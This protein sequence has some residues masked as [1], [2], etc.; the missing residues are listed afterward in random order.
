MAV[1]QF[2]P[3][4]LNFGSCAQRVK[5]LISTELLPFRGS[6]GEVDG[7]CASCC[8]LLMDLTLRSFLLI[9]QCPALF[10]KR[11]HALGFLQLGHRRWILTFRGTLCL[12]SSVLA[13]FSSSVCEHA[14]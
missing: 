2:R 13:P 5:Q 8:T 7:K 6:D 1:R 9:K 10:S 3:F 11:D 4:Y 12:S 14:P